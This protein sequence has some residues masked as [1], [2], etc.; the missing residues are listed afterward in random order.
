MRRKRTLLALALAIVSGLVAGIASIRYLQDRPTPLLASESNAE[1]QPVAVAARDLGV[2]DVLK[3]DD[4]RLVDWPAGSVP[5]GYAGSMAEVIGRSLIT[6]VSVNEPLMATKLADTGLYGLVPLI[7]P[8]MRALSVRVDEVVG[9][10]GFVTPRT[11]VDV[12]LTMTVPGGRDPI[13]K[14]ILQNVQTLAAGQEIQQNEEGEPMTVTVVT[15]LVTPEDAEKLS[16]ASSQGKIQ[17]ALRHTLDLETVETSGQYASRLF[18]VAS[19]STARRVIRSAPT[20]AT[21][22]ESIIEMYQGGVRTL[23]SY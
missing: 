15:V 2:G 9:V 21:S 5:A 16:L 1:T 20:S 19:S 3:I 22:S 7:P 4:V 13:S 11:R 14:V 10:A 8:G 23:I 18:S 17:M 6:D 12:I